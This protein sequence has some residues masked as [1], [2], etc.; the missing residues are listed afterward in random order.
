MRSSACHVGD[1]VSRLLDFDI[2]LICLIYLINVYKKKNYNFPPGPTPLPVIGN[3]HLLRLRRQDLSLLKLS[4]KYGPIFTIH[5]G[6]NKAVVLTGLETIKEALLEDGDSFI[7][8]T[9]LPIF[10]AI[11]HGNGVFFTSGNKWKITRRFMLSCMKNLGMGKKMIEDKMIEELQFLND[12]IES[13]NGKQFKLREFA[14]APTNIIFSMMFGNRFDYKDPTYIRILDLVDDIIVLLGSRHLQNYKTRHYHYLINVKS[15]TLLF[16]IFNIYPILGK[17][18]KT[19]KVILDKIDEICMVLKADI[20]SKRQTMDY[21]CLHTFIEAII[22][23]QGVEGINKDTLFD[24]DNIIA[25]LLDMVM[26][27]T[28]TISTTL[29]WGILLMMKYPHIQKLVHKEI[30]TVLQSGRPASYEDRKVMPYT[31]AV[32]HEIQRFANVI[33]HIPHATSKDTKFKGYHIP[34]GTIVIPLLTSVLYDKNHWEN[35]YQFDPNHFLDA[36][37]NFVKKEAF[38]PFSIGRRACVGESLAKMEMFIFFTG[39]LQKF[40]FSAP[41]GIKDSD[42]V[43]DADPC[44]TVRPKPHLECCAEINLPFISTRTTKSGL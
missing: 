30:H 25:T 4:E 27:G 1:S 16:Q 17:F 28:E 24:D 33:P 43:L 11:Q 22:A 10:E 41:P 13:F 38:M 19:H 9:V 8:R 14:C 21:N 29:Q 40:T 42:L 3:L 15:Q 34:K 32:A 7:D 37:G 12:K 26:A 2:T 5:L 18:M 6:M 39:I 20:N 23:K 36:E 31:L 44:F 35:P